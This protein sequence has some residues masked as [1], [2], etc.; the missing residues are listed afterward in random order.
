[1]R[2]GSGVSERTS[3]E[4]LTGAHSQRCRPRGAYF[5]LSL[6]GGLIGTCREVLNHPRASVGVGTAYD[7][8]QNQKELLRK[9]VRS[10]VDDCFFWFWKRS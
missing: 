4:P 8:F 9:H 2:S 7:R 3:A 6:G 10:P 1:V 5:A